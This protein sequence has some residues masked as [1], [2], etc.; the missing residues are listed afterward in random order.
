MALIDNARFNQFLPIALMD[1]TRF[2]HWHTWICFDYPIMAVGKDCFNK[3][4]CVLF[5]QGTCEKTS[6]LKIGNI[7]LA[8][9]RQSKRNIIIKQVAFSSFTLKFSALRF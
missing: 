4:T 8:I 5:N 7:Q 1:L 9:T 3:A 2:C 6:D